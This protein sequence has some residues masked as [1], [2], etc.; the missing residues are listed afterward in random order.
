MHD[1]VVH[2]DMS[3]KWDELI[4][5]YPN[6]VAVAKFLVL[7]NW[8]EMKMKFKALDEALTIMDISTHVL[9][10]VRYHQ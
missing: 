4:N 5:N 3:K 10:Q 9:C 1:L 7:S 8:K 6:N 2:L